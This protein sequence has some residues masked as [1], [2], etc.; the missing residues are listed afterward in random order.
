M[1]S[2]FN[3]ANYKGVEGYRE[4]HF[5]NG[6]DNISM[7]EQ[8]GEIEFVSHVDTEG[9]TAENVTVNGNNGIYVFKGDKSTIAWLEDDTLLKITAPVDKEEILKIA[10]SIKKIN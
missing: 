2:S 6:I 4:L 8:N 5:N 7:Y 3:L 9:V 1:P 10:I